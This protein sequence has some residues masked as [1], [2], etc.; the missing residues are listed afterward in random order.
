MQVH[1][2]IIVCNDG[3]IYIRYIIPDATL[4]HARLN[5]CRLGI[6]YPELSEMQVRA[7]FQAAISLTSQGVTVIPEIMV[8]LVGT[9]QARHYH[10]SI[11]YV[12]MLV[13]FYA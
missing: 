2:Y 7:I 8:P 9:P 11:C 10:I 3:Y 6:S 4:M 1:T 5:L 12:F 13:F